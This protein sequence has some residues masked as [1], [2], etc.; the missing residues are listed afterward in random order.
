MPSAGSPSAA[1]LRAMAAHETLFRWS[2]GLA[3]DDAHSLRSSRTARRVLGDI[4]PDAARHKLEDIRLLFARIRDWDVT[5]CLRTIRVPVTVAAGDRDPIIRYE[6][7]CELAGVIPGVR[8][9]TFAGTGHTFF[10]ESLE[11]FHCC[12]HTWLKGFI[13]SREAAAS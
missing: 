4:R 5:D 3:A 11:A 2:Y 1:A 8:L 13:V 12:L 9:V 10:A 7:S 6:H